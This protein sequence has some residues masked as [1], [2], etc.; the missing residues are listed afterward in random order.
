MS[1]SFDTV[2]SFNK[3][4]SLIKSENTFRVMKQISKEDVELNKKIRSIKNK[5]IAA[6]FN[7]VE[8]DGK[9]FVIEEYVDGITLD[10][11]LKSGKEINDYIVSNIIKSVCDGLGA[12]HAKGIVHRDIN[13][14]NIILGSD[15]VKIIDF[16]ICRTVKLAKSNDTEILGTQGYA[17]PEQFG[18]KQSGT[19]ADIYAVGVLINVMLTGHFP[20]EGISKGIFY[21]IIKKCTAIDENDRYQDVSQ[22][23]FAIDNALKNKSSIILP[24][25]RTGVLWKKIVASVYY[26]VAGLFSVL[27]CISSFNTLQNAIFTTNFLLFG[28]WIPIPIATNYRDWLGRF[29]LTAIMSLSV[30]IFVQYLLV[31]ISLAISLI[32]ILAMN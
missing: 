23:V 30:R 20:N 13:P 2:K 21:P 31:F 1:T 32:S 29:K 9:Y 22:L 19:R 26:V 14:N 15:G 18:F 3:I 8:S 24:G 10:E 16:G 7:I 28:L 11:Y 12:L 25:F 6:V 17:A 5:H 27:M 4:T